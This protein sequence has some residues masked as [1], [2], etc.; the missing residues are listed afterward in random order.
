MNN[1]IG[2]Y[3]G[4]IYRDGKLPDVGECCVMV[5]DKE[6]ED[7][8]RVNEIKAYN[9]IRCAGCHGCPASQVGEGK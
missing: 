2:F 4:N 1:R 5:T 3:T 9:K 6:L 8:A 7:E